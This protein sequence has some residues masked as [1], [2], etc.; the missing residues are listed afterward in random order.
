MMLHVI[1]DP[2]PRPVPALEV[3]N[4]ILDH[5]GE[6]YRQR[7]A[8][9]PKQ[10]HPVVILDQMQEESLKQVIYIPR[11]GALANTTSDQLAVLTVEFVEGARHGAD[12]GID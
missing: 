11:F 2:F 10:Q 4:V 5:H 12:D 8:A 3:D 1:G 7:V 6:V 9:L